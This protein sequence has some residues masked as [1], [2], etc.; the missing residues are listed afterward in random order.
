MTIDLYFLQVPQLVPAPLLCGC[1]WMLIPFLGWSLWHTFRDGL[2][3]L[4]RLHQV[5]CDRC[6]FFT[7]D[8]R[9][10]CTVNPYTALTEEA[11]ECFDFEPRQGTIPSCQRRCKS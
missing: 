6:A 9:L 8:Y 4:K 7:G 3:R 1:I 5:P 11:I 2:H 10:K